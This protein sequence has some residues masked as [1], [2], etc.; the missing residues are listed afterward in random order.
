[1]TYR[2]PFYTE[3][4][5]PVTG[6]RV[7]L[8]PRSQAEKDAIREHLRIM[9]M[10]LR[11]GIVTAEDVMSRLRRLNPR[12]KGTRT[13]RQAM[14]GWAGHIADST[15][16]R[17]ET[18]LRTSLA[19]FADVEIETIDRRALAEWVQDRH[20]HGDRGSTIVRTWRTLSAIVRSALARG[21]IDVIPWGDWHPP[22]WLKRAPRPRECCK[23][24]EQA[25]A[26][27]LAAREIDETISREKIPSL[28]ARIGCGLL[29]GLRAGE[30]AGL[31]WS[32][33]AQGRV[34]IARSWDK[35]TTKTRRA[36]AVA[37]PPELDE[38]L[39]R[40]RARLARFP[41]VY[42]EDRPLFPRMLRVVGENFHQAHNVLT[43]DELRRAVRA[44]GLPSA[45]LWTIHSLRE[46]F[47]RLELTA[48]G[49]VA[50]TM[51]RARHT[52]LASTQEYVRRIAS[53]DPPAPAWSLPSAPTPKELPQ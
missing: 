5:H 30:I 49:S 38:L 43:L 40:Y 45:E 2:S 12:R 53:D 22:R 28:E 1:V 6:R 16:L 34:T 20:D 35:R 33:F 32:D 7:Q 23:R 19:R 41:E 8:L 26:L 24:P 21:W 36:A 4:R 13:L 31:R 44:A 51:L 10:Q 39:A 46:S 18:D 14:I 27:I 9:R 50:H 47:V 48:S 25:L 42:G 52:K 17:V 15:R 37:V 3:F 29:L 11:V